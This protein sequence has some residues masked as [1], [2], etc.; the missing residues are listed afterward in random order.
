M[1]DR[2]S[3]ARRL[4]AATGLAAALVLAGCATA[5]PYQPLSAS[6]RSEGG[7][8]ETQLDQSKWRVTFAG[9]TLTSRDTVEAY[10]LYRAAELTVEQKGD[11]F[12]IVNRYMEH[13][14]R[15]EVRPNPFYDPMWDYYGWRPYW[16]YQGRGMGWAYWYPYHNQASF[17]TTQVEKFEASAEIVMHTGT[18]PA[19][20]GNLFDAR[21]VIARLGPTI[22]RPK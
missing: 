6:A 15:N 14:V 7:Y 22:V 12:E 2:S 21:E 9:N 19:G 10:L 17:D 13:E 18:K 16:R 1:T 11:W 3:K 8:S 4:L 20:D 5:T